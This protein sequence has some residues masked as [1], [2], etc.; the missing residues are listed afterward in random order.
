M[1]LDKKK[2][3]YKYGDMAHIEFDDGSQ[4]STIA[5]PYDYPNWDELQDGELPGQDTEQLMDDWKE[6]LKNAEL[7]FF[8][9][10]KNNDLPK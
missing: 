1:R 2:T 9:L 6:T 10:D 5:D 8:D 7:R 3:W 4:L